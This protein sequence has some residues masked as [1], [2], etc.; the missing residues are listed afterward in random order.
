MTE[1]VQKCRSCGERL[2]LSSFHK[3]AS[4]KNGHRKECRVCG[5]AKRRE[6]R[7][8]NIDAER[9]RERKKNETKPTRIKRKQASQFRSKYLHQNNATKKLRYAVKK[10]KI[11]KPS[12]CS[13]CGA[14]G[15][16]DGHHEDYRK[17]FEV[18]WLCKTCHGRR[19]TEINDEIR[20]GD[21]EKWK[22]RGFNV[23]SKLPPAL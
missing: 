21:A 15:D 14:S 3:K 16:L 18:V 19:H 10:G 9:V 23:Q 4:E 11:Q 20:R 6:Y 8:K 22:V 17:C 1:T 13:S 2:P 7:I 12:T 5:N